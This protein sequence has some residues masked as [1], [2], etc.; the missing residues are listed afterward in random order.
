MKRLV[1]KNVKVQRGAHG[2][3]L[4]AIGPV[5]KGEVVAEYWGEIVT[6]ETMI[7]SRGKYFFE[8]ENHMAING[9]SRKNMARYINHSCS[10]NCEPQENEKQQRVFIVAKRNIKA[11]EEFGYDY[12]REYWDEHIKPIGCRCGCG[13]NGP[14]RWR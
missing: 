8:L 13:G 2:L 10:P 9:K 6:E 1:H 4:F 3:G 5:V 12:G 7:R 14:R 11:G